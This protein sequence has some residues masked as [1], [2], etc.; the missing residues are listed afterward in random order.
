MDKMFFAK[1]REGAIVPTKRKE[2]AGYD[3]YACFDEDYFEIKNGETRPVPTGIAW[4]CS[5]KYYMQIEERSGMGVKGIKKSAGV[6]DSG[7]RGEFLIAITN[8]TGKTLL[9]SKLE[10]EELSTSYPQL[11]QKTCIIIPYAKAIVQGVVHEVPVL[12][13]QEISYEDLLKMDSER[14]SG[15]FGSSGK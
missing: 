5:P 11:D 1:M 4:A 8:L 10:E 14:K 15:R 12:D 7:Y 9:I 6:F 2:D 3:F 13:V